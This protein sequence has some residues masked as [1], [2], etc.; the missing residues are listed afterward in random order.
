MNSTDN[1]SQ[2]IAVFY[3]K[4]SMASHLTQNKN[5]MFLK[6]SSPLFWPSI[7][8]FYSGFSA[9]AP[10]SFSAPWMQQ[11]LYYLRTFAFPRYKHPSL[12]SPTSKSLLKCH[13]LSKSFPDQH[14]KKMNHFLYQI[15]SF[16]IALSLFI[17]FQHFILITHFSL[18]KYKYQEVIDFYSVYYYII[19]S[20]TCTYD[21]VC[22]YEIFV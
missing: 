7:S 16:P 4:P 19:V 17:F 22:V 3:I 2:I 12:P 15:L 14:I 5:Q 11:A 20:R 6:V 10:L 18:P 9:Q 13:F 8:L 1:V 21:M